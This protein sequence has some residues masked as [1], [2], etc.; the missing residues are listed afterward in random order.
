MSWTPGF[1]TETQK[2]RLYDSFADKM[3]NDMLEMKMKSYIIKS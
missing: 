2:V 1:L 3:E